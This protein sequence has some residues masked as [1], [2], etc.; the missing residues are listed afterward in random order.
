ML[1]Y[2]CLTFCCWTLDLHAETGGSSERRR[3]SEGG[4]GDGGGD[5]RHIQREK[6]INVK[7]KNGIEG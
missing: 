7:M 5:G 2:G 4:G 1:I 6:L 3:R